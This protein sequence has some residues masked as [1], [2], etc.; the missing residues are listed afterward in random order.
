MAGIYGQRTIV[1]RCV[2]YV[3]G[4]AKIVLQKFRHRVYTFHLPR[5][6]AVLDRNR[7]FRTVKQFDFRAL[8]IV[9]IESSVSAFAE[10]A[11]KIR[12]GYVVRIFGV[13]RAHIQKHIVYAADFDFFAHRF[14]L[15]HRSGLPV[16]VR[17]FDAVFSRRYASVGVGNKPAVF[18]KTI[19]I[20]NQSARAD[21]VRQ[22]ICFVILACRFRP[23]IC[24]VDFFSDRFL[25]F[26]LY[27]KHVGK[28]FEIVARK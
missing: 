7:R 8:R 13:K 22:K 4:I 17:S 15:C 25:P 5:F 23:M 26:G 12:I 24:V 16:V 3:T 11:R 27:G 20:E 18:L 28:V 19:E 9:L 21:I 6:V 14:K 2:A 1:Q 10:F